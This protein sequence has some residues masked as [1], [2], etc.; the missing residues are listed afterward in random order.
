MDEAILN[1]IFGADD[2]YEIPYVQLGEARAFPGADTEDEPYSV[3]FQHYFLPLASQ[4]K[5][6]FLSELAQNTFPQSAHV[7][8]IR[9]VS[10]VG[11][12]ARKRSRSS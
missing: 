7:T 1:R 12:A 10:F 9:D 3:I 8:F 4:S 6:Y 11:W 2:V 5:Q